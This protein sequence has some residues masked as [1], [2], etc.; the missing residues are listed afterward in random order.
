[1][2]TIMAIMIMAIHD[3]AGHD[4]AD[5]SHAGTPMRAMSM[6][7]RNFGRAFLIGIMLN[8]GFV[9]AEVVYGVLGGSVALVADGAHN[10]TDV[11]GLA[12]AWLATVLARR[13]PTRAL[14]LRPRPDDDPGGA[15]QAA[16]LLLA[17]G[18]IFSKRC[19]V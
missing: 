5:H 15:D 17:T 9:G 18:A 1:M 3:Q 6:R 12:A 16:L 2:T 7:R 19:S 14:H 13:A 4:H 10:L 8:V 11:L